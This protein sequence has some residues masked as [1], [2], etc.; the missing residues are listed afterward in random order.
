[1]TPD[2]RCYYQLVSTLPLRLC[3]KLD[4]ADLDQLFR[5]A[6]VGCRFLA[7]AKMFSIPGAAPWVLQGVQTRVGTPWILQGFWKVPPADAGERRQPPPDLA[8]VPP[9]IAISGSVALG[10]AR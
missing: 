4:R 2:N 8:A 7:D 9:S 1:M 5:E 3:D 10:I 6:S